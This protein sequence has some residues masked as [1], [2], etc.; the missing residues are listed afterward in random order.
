[1]LGKN[2]QSI[3][4]KVQRT[5]NEHIQQKR[6]KFRGRK[7]WRGRVAQKLRKHSNLNRAYILIGFLPISFPLELESFLKVS[8]FFSSCEQFSLADQELSKI[9]PLGPG[10]WRACGEK[11]K[12]SLYFYLIPLLWSRK[13]QQIKGYAAS[14]LKGNL[15][16]R[17]VNV[18]LISNHDLLKDQDLPLPKLFSLRYLQGKI[19]APELAFIWQK[20]IV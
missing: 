6:A 5:R 15:K 19:R 17:L 1:M 12:G 10:I 18:L 4:E 7:R 11:S 20:K 16:S 8:P 3:L 2:M 14:D 13:N 9:S